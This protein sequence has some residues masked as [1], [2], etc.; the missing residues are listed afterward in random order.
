MGGRI[1]RKSRACRT[2]IL[3]DVSFF[4]Q[5]QLTNQFVFRTVGVGSDLR[6]HYPIIKYIS[7]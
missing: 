7:Q 5:N 2:D 6:F 1:L 4:S 3:R